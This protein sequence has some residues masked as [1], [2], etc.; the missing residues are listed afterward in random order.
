MNDGAV[1]RT[2]TFK[3]T[4]IYINWNRLTVPSVT[5][6]NRHLKL[7]HTFF[8]TARL[9]PHKDLGTRDNIL[10]NQLTLRTSVSRL[11]HLV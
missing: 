10:Y 2:L 5:D 11:L 3:R 4:Y 1:N 8:V 9:W 6:A 7:P